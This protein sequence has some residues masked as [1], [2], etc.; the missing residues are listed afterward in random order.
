MAKLT[1]LAFN[2]LHAFCKACA[3]LFMVFIM[4]CAPH[5]QP[6]STLEMWGFMVLGGILNYSS[7]I[8]YTKYHFETSDS[9]MQRISGDG[10]GITFRVVKYDYNFKYIVAVRQVWK[11]YDCDDGSMPV[12]LL[13][14][15]EYW[16]IE[17]ANDKVHGPMSYEDFLK[18]AQDDYWLKKLDLGS[19]E[20][21]REEN[22]KK[23]YKEITLES[24]IGPH[25]LHP[26]EQQR[27]TP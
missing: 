20:S 9:V 10:R 16:F 15:Y 22:I 3:A 27:S 2:Y 4:S 6:P 21:I 7:Q 8:G 18:K 17:L 12:V 11:G 1:T 19:L 13:D 5:G 23:G 26:K 24:Q 14:Q 25:C